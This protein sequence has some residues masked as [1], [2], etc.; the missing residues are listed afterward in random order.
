M[1]AVQVLLIGSGRRSAVAVARTVICD[2]SR[3]GVA[4]DPPE[5]NLSATST[6][7][8]PSR[9]DR[10]A[11]WIGVDEPDPKVRA[12]WTPAPDPTPHEPPSGAS[13]RRW[14][15]PA[16]RPRRQRRAGPD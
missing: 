1:G 7:W 14:G 16:A 15:G 12:T 10:R 4:A 8:R 5:P 6:G 13:L 11:D 2:P 3:S 9:Q